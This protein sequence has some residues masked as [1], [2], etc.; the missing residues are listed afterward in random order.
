MEMY[1]RYKPEYNKIERFYF[2]SKEQVQYST[3]EDTAVFPACI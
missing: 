1:L 3:L 2:V